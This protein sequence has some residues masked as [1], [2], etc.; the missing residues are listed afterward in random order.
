MVT[1]NNENEVSAYHVIRIFA[2]AAFVIY[3]MTNWFFP[4]Y[5][6]AFNGPIISKV[7]FV[8]AILFISASFY[9]WLRGGVWFVE[10]VYN[11]EYVEFK[12]KYLTTPFGEKQLVRIPV[13]SLY[14][15]KI[16]T[17]RFGLRKTIVL[18]QEKKGKIFQYPPIPIGSLV[19]KKR[20]EVMDIINRY[21]VKI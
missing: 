13:D 2:T 5:F 20:D 10:F 4:K 17:S 19:E 6:L 8:Y 21:A 15:Y 14:A 3:I 1:I 16:I 12:F 18:Y 11:D 7:G 9:L